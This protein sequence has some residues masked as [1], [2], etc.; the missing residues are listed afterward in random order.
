MLRIFLFA[1]LIANL[2]AC[3]TLRYQVSTV[4]SENV[5]TNFEFSNDDL[6]LTYGF[7]AEGGYLS[8][9]ITNKSSDPIYIDWE[10]SNFIFNGYSYDFFSNMTTISSLGAYN[11]YSN[12]ELIT[13]NQNPGVIGNTSGRYSTKTTVFSDKKFT[14]IPPRSFSN[15]KSISLD[16]PWLNFS[17]IKKQDFRKNEAILVFRTYIAYSKDKNMT[18][19]L[20][21]DNEFWVSSVELVKNKND[22]DKLKRNDKFFTK[23]HLFD[24]TKTIIFGTAC[25]GGLAGFFYLLSSLLSAFE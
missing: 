24:S 23:N 2:Y 17:K 16:F 12:S 13:I 18:D 14:Q 20:F 7:W 25:A 9:A 22:L 5:N 8:M 19:L 6:I 3:T 15:S 11:N 1:V 21:V 4:S 10:R